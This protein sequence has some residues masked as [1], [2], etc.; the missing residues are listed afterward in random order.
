MKTRRLTVRSSM[1]FGLPYIQSKSEFESTMW[2]QWPWYPM[3]YSRRKGVQCCTILNNLLQRNYVEITRLD[4][5]SR[6]AYYVKIL[7]I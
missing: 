1:V 3:Q 4:S 7:H 2:Q 5:K 6:L